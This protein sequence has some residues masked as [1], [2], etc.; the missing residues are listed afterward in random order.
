M[1]F[2][3]NEE[4]S[5][6]ETFIIDISNGIKFQPSITI[7]NVRGEEGIYSNMHQIQEPRKGWAN[8]LPLCPGNVLEIPGGAQC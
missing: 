6:G 4:I 5:L 2:I 1:F 8:D 3:S 7:T